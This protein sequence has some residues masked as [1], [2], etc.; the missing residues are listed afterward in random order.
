MGWGV[1]VVEGREGGGKERV[2]SVVGEWD[3]AA[4]EDG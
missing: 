1:C 3:P 2:R 4:W